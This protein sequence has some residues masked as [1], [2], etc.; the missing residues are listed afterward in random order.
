MKR[1]V[2]LLVAIVVSGCYFVPEDR[3]WSEDVPN[4]GSVPFNI[5]FF[6]ARHVSYIEDHEEY[7]QSPGETYALG[8]GDCEDYAILAMFMINRDTDSEAL[9]ATDA[10][11]AWLIVDGEHWEP[12]SATLVPPRSFVR[13]YTYDQAKAAAR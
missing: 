6:V 10:T 9:M 4:V 5:L 7:W 1:I 2:I 8:T 3:E 12:I 13:L 11:H